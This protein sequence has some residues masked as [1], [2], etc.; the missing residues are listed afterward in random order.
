MC[1]P[2]RKNCP[3]YSELLWSTFPPTRNEY[4]LRIPVFNRNAGKYGPEKPQIRTL[5]MQFMFPI[6][7]KKVKIV[8]KFHF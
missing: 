6:N 8:S 3:S 2:L 4:G 5:S 7:W 1:L